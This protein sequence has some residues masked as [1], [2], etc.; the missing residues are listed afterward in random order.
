VAGVSYICREDSPDYSF[1]P[2]VG[3]FG[4][5]FGN[6]V[7]GARDGSGFGLAVLVDFVNPV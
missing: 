2:P 3:P 6:G 5:Y 7:H 1:E 4:E